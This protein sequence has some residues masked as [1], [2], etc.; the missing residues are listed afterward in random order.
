MKNL[1][2]TSLLLWAAFAPGAFA[3]TTNLKE[4]DVP[5]AVL[6][7]FRQKFPHAEGVAWMKESDQY[8]GA[9]FRD[10]NASTEV[11]YTPEG[12]WTQTQREITFRELPDSA[13]RYCKL[14]YGSLTLSKVNRVTTRRYGV[15]YDVIAVDNLKKVILTFDMNGQM[16]DEREEA[17]KPEAP[18][19]ET[20]SPGTK[21]TLI[22]W[23]VVK[24]QQ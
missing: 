7:D 16:V 22:K 18:E 9:R 17:L 20:G 13:A 2:W 1:L 10:E 24:G 8:I 3:Q 15:L 6:Y 21:K 4:K 11:V 19:R 5:P 23:P 12:E 14:N